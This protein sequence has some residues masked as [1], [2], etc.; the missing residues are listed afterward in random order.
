MEIGALEHAWVAS[1]RQ[2]RVEEFRTT[3]FAGAVFSRTQFRDPG[4]IGI[5]ANHRRSS[6]H[7]RNRNRQSEIAKADDCDFSDVCHFPAEI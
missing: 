5:V 3:N 4:L 7:E 2:G 6:S 1:Q